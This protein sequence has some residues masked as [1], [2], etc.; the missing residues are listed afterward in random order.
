M[1]THHETL[2]EIA[3]TVLFLKDGRLIRQGRHAELLADSAAYRR[4][5]V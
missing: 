4:L 5:W 3:D 2:A 1:I